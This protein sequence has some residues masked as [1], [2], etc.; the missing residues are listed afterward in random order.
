MTLYLMNL[1][2]RTYHTLHIQVMRVKDMK[3]IRLEGKI[4]FMILIVNLQ[5]LNS[6]LDK[7]FIDNKQCKEAIKRYAICDCEE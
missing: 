3:I 1:I 5:T 4:L 7:R 6:N 2:H